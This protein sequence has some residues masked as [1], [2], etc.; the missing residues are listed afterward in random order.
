MADQNPSATSTSIQGAV[1]SDVGD[2]FGVVAERLNTPLVVVTAASR[3]ERAGCVVG[4]HTQCSIDPV[5]YALWLSKANH[6]YRVA[7]FSTSLAVHFLGESDHDLAALFGGETGDDVDKFER[8]SWQ[9]GPDE[10]PLLDGC[11]NRMILRRVSTTDDGSDHVCIVGEVVEV[12]ADAGF[13][14]LRLS[15]AE[16]IEAGHEARARPVPH[17][18]T[19]DG[20]PP[21]PEHASPPEHVPSLEQ[22]TRTELED[23]AAG[24][25]HQIDL[26]EAVEGAEH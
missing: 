20:D 1:S 12:T 18:L 8:C 6:T 23:I 24:S 16:D 7:L 9:S 21:S 22:A 25:G 10:V 17:N 3:D 19:A 13:V 5:R 14:P 26:S 11:P 2:R 15:D 4:F